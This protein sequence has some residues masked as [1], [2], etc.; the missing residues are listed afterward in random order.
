MSGSTDHEERISEL[1]KIVSKGNGRLPLVQEISSMK[2]YAKG[3]L[4]GLSA[5]AILLMTMIANMQNSINDLHRS[6][7]DLTKALH[8]RGAISHDFGTYAVRHKEET[9]IATDK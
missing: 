9:E 5:A 8:D 2:G 6:V 1:E 3:V 7:L 4:F